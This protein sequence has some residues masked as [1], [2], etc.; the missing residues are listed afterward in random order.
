[1]GK[2]QIILIEDMDGFMDGRPS[3]E[4]ILDGQDEETDMAEYLKIVVEKL[5]KQLTP[6]EELLLRR[7]F[8]LGEHRPT[9]EEFQQR[10]AAVRELIQQTEA[11]AQKPKRRSSPKRGKRK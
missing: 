7:R 2:R 10:F 9:L 5:L 4:E 8:S 1:M 11:K 6:R 3:Q